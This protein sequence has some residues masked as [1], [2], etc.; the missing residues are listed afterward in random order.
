MAVAHHFNVL[1]SNPRHQ[2]LLLDLPRD[3]VQLVFD[4]LERTGRLSYAHLRYLQDLDAARFHCCAED[5]QQEWVARLASGCSRL[6]DLDLSKCTQLTDKALALLGQEL[7]GL[8]HL[9]VGMCVQVRD[10]GLLQL[11]PLTGLASLDISGCENVTGEGLAVVANFPGLTSLLCNQCNGLEKGSLVHLRGLQGLQNLQLGWCIALTDADMQHLSHL[12]RLTCLT[13]SYTKV[14]DEG[15][16]YLKPLA[17]L[18][19]LGLQGCAI[20][21]AGCSLLA[22]APFALSL[23]DLNIGQCSRV[24]DAGV[25]ALAGLLR[26]QTLDVAYTA[27]QDAG[28]ASLEP[29]KGLVHLNLDSCRFSSEG[30]KVLQ[31]LTA[32]ETLNL[33]DTMAGDMSLMYLSRTT[34]LKRLSLAYTK[35]SDHGLQALS[36]LTSLR[37]LNLDIGSISDEGLKSW[38]GKLTA[39]TALDMFGAHITDRGAAIIASHLTQLQ[40]LEL[41][42][43]GLRDMGCIY[44]ATLP[45]L[46]WLSLAQ[47]VRIGNAGVRALTQL[48]GLEV[49][50]LNLTSITHR[51]KD[52][53]MQFK[54][55]RALSICDTRMPDWAVQEIQAAA[56]KLLIKH[57]YKERPGML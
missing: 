45:S 43:G 4:E 22:S 44:L 15:L 31:K 42:G 41:C 2:A 53:L 5:V 11:K 17:R 8:R 40:R 27:I 36:H 13:L 7:P 3:L 35:M 49:L 56:P 39:L 20:S 32:L 9:R 21:N 38:V 33:S 51:A 23:T 55:L 6:R 14:T 34:S 12:T 18:C 25:A 1:L 48:S 26:L 37:D 54:A 28:L 57:R 47:N 29:L 19:R 52:D 30:C 24:G 46:T 10:E 16:P 50:N